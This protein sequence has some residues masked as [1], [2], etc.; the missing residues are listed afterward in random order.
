MLPTMVA[1]TSTSTKGPA[2]PVEDAHHA[3]VAR[4]QPR[5][6][7]RGGRVHREQFARHMDHARQPAGAGHVDAVVVLRAQVQRGE[8]AV[9]ELR[10]QRRVAADQR[11]GAVVVALGL[12]DLVAADAA[13]LADRAV[14]R[15][16]QVGLRQRPHAGLQR[17]REEVVEALVG[18]DVGFGGLGHVHAVAADE[19]ADQP[20]RALRRAAPTR[21]ARPG[22]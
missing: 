9:V 17:A 13:E 21:C 22:A 14:H 3:F 20:R 15:A 8:V 10:G 18:S 16:H 6:A 1:P 7:A 4:E 12:E 5:H 2:P 11:G 19:P